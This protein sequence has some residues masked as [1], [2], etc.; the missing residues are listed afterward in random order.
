MSSGNEWKLHGMTT[1]KI[2]VLFLV[3]FNYFKKQ[4]S[5]KRNSGKRHVEWNCSKICSDAMHA[6]YV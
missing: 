4:T 2:S 5:F 6:S 1:I 3:L